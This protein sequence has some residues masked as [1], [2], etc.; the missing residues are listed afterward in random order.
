MKHYFFRAM[1]VGLICFLSACS[2][3]SQQGYEKQPPPLP[4]WAI[5]SERWDRSGLTISAYASVPYN[6]SAYTSSQ[7]PSLAGEIHNEMDLAEEAAYRR[8]RELLSEELSQIW[9]DFV[10]LEQ[11]QHLNPQSVKTTVSQNLRGVFVNKRLYDEQRRIFHIQVFLPASRI[12]AILEEA[13]GIMVVLGDNGK[14]GLAA[15]PIP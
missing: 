8:A 6:F 15:K 4:V 10:N 13:F 2:L 9:L 12:S 3:F 7:D 14:L 1:I 5:E 11:G